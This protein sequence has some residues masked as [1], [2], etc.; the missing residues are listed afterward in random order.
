MMTLW[1]DG[2]KFAKM[3]LFTEYEDVGE[4]DFRPVGLPHDA[5]I[6]QSSSLYEDFTGWYKKA[7]F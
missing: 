6:Y 3:P 4:T 5:L 2:W 7:F 1:N